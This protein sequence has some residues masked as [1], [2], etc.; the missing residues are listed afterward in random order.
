[1]PMNKI[2]KLIKELCPNG[3]E[4]KK[5]GEIGSF[6]RGNGLQKTDFTEKGVGCIHYGQIYTYYNLFTDKT[7]SYVSS[8]LAE[9]LKKVETGDIVLACTSE[10]IEDICKCVVWE[11][12]ETIVTGGHASIFKHNQN[13]RYI[14]Y[15]FQSNLF[16]VQKIKYVYGAKVIDIKNDDLSK[17]QIPLPPLPIQTEIVRI[18]DKFVEQQEQLEKLIELR[19]KQYE[20]YREEMLK[21]KEGEVWETKR[22]G[23]IAEVT[24]LAGFEFTEYVEYSDE[25]KIIALRGLNVKDGKLVLDDVKYID[26]SNFSKLNRSKLLKNDLLYTYVGTVGQSA[27]IEEDDKYYLA[28]NVA[29]IRVKS[30]DVLISKY[31]LFYLLSSKFKNSELEKL[32]ASSSMKNIT[33]EKIRK[34]NIVFPSVSKQKD[35]IN[36]LVNFESSIAALTSALEASRRRYEYYRDEMMRF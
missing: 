1:M 34:F 35:I 4:W 3:V 6:V 25:G 17:I 22:L 12:S 16:V 18:L 31:L 14:A 30:Q 15:F 11:G 10:N 33:M 23:E 28:P 36:T 27:I 32:T 9:K 24:K 7:K 21:P 13:S 5:L 29:M 20:Y 2:E 8:D 19:K 26:N